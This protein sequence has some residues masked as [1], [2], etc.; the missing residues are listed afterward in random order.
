LTAAFLWAQ[1]E[2]AQRTTATRLGI[3]RSYLEAASAL[4]SLGLRL[5]IVPAECEHNAHMFYLLL[6]PHVRQ[7]DVLKELNA[8]SVNAVFHYVPLHSSPAGK[9]YGRVS[10]SMDVTDDVAARLIRLPLWVGM[11]QDA[12]QTVVDRFAEALTTRA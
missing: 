7:V 8:R 2:E 6:P 4:G 9:R 3:W 5:P 11:P 12:P 10:G 1:L